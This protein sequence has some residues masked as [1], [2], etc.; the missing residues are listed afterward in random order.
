MR[1]WKNI[2]FILYIAIA[3]CILLFRETLLEEI[4]WVVGPLIVL[5]ALESI[6]ISVVS[7]SEKLEFLED[8]KFYS[9][10]V[11]LILAGIILFVE[12]DYETVC[13]IW[14][15][16]SILRENG[17]LKECFEL[18]KHKIPAG[19]SLI[20]SLVSIYFSI[21]LI[22]TPTEHHANLH[23]YLLSIELISAVLFPVL[24]AV[25]ANKFLAK[26]ENE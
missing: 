21:G 5:Y 14:A 7:K 20:E 3:I 26:Q 18:L 1:V 19:L 8:L 9:S 11:E 12:T 17:E 4:R 24:R 25:Y 22:L 2:K 10:L 13:I 23:L 16:W 15:V 6:I